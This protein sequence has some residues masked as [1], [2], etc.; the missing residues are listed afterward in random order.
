M[1]PNSFKDLFFR[2]GHLLGLT[3]AVVVLAGISALVNLPRIEDPRIATRNALVITEFPG[4]SAERVESLVT[5][6]LEEE[7]REVEEIKNIDSTSRANIS[8]ISIELQDYIDGSTNEQAFSRVR[9]RLGDAQSLLPLGAGK[10]QFDDERGASAFA[11]VVGLSVT[12]DDESKIGL[13]GRLGDELADRFRNLAGAERVRVYGNP[14]EEITITLDAG[15]LAAQGLTAQ[16]VATLVAQSDPKNPAGALR[17]SQ[18]DLFIEVAGEFDSL[19]TIRNLV[20]VEGAQGQLLR[21]GDVATVSRGWKKP[22]DTEGY[23][24]GRRTVFVATSAE[25]DVRIDKWQESANAVL[26]DFQAQIDSGIA[27]DVVFQQSLY[28]AERLVSLSNNLLL[29]ALV[30]ML[31]VL[32][33]LGWRAA[34]IVGAALPLSAL[35]TLFG[36]TFFDQQIHQMSMFGMII[37]IGLLIDNAIVV[38]DEIQKRLQNGVERRVAVA[39][40]VSHLSAP[41]FASTVTTVLGFMPIFLLSGNIGDFIGPIA[42]SVVLALI[43]SF[44]ISMTVIAALGGRLL[45]Q[46][47]DHSK[48]HSENHSHSTPWWHAGIQVPALTRMSERFFKL[49]FARPAFTVLLALVLPLLGFFAATKLSLEFFPP[50]ERDQF[51]IEVWMSDEASLERTK[52]LA[53]AIESAVGEYEGIQQLSWLVG[54]SHPQFYYNRIMKQDSNAA[55]AHAMVQTDTAERAENLVVELQERLDR[56]FP[57]A[58]II[59][60]P[61]AQGPP[62]DA[63]LGFRIEGPSLPVLIEKGAELRRIMHDVPAITHTRASLNTRAKLA[64]EAEQFAAQSVGLSLDR[65]GA[66]AAR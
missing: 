40:A 31:V 17:D 15:E 44:M 57:E 19:A 11:L 13:V 27:V 20:L 66:T 46:S 49:A 50:A 53:N 43:S 42:I 47:K 3:I 56:Q 14:A 38:T 52:D 51:E 24:N 6:K 2:N 29:G 45:P 61:F 55:Y 23:V 35:A 12:N 62:V 36:L 39:G 22:T 64:F 60:A 63:P 34:L 21:L 18:R 7:L 25:P 41:L 4:A 33:G 30:I 58:Q 37:A 48:N 1:N 54:G 16:Q 5:K 65:C 59:V 10:P 28:A 9:D 32:V 26:Q 8:L